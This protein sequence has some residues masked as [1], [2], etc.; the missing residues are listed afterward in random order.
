MI[1]R[2]E[3]EAVTDAF[4]SAAIAAGANKDMYKLFGSLLDLLKN[5][6]NHLEA[7]RSREGMISLV[8][9]FSATDE[10]LISIIGTIFALVP[11]LQSRI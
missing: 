1:S 3:A 9:S 6:Q 2:E 10:T 4:E 7:L 8:Q 11:F 5:Y